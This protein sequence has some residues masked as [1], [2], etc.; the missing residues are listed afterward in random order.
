MQWNIVLIEE[1]DFELQIIEKFISKYIIGIENKSFLNDRFN[2]VLRTL[3]ISLHWRVV[4][5][6]SSKKILS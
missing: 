3:F 2:N 4:I 5:D 6:L 1:I